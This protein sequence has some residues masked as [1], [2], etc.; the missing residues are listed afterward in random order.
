MFAN[1]HMT[2]LSSPTHDVPLEPGSR[3]NRVVVIGARLNGLEPEAYL[4]DLLTRIGEHPIN[5]LDEPLPWNVD[6]PAMQAAA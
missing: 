1:V 5:R 2:M 3:G 4:R 6:R